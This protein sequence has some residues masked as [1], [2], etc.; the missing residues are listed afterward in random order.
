[1]NNNDMFKDFEK[2]FG[3]LSEKVNSKKEILQHF[4]DFLKETIESINDSTY[5][6]EIINIV[7]EY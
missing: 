2:T 4:A 1:M 7:K 6:I 5:D 3:I